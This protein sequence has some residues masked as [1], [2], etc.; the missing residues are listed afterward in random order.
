MFEREV[1]DGVWYFSKETLAPG[2]RKYFL[3]KPEI[4]YPPFGGRIDDEEYKNLI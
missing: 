2:G 1:V 3:S 4:L